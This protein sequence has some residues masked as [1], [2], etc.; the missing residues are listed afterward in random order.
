MFSRE[1]AKSGIFTHQTPWLSES[2]NGIPF[3]VTLILEGSVPLILKPVYPIPAP[4][5]EVV[6]TDGVDEIKK[7]KS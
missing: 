6:T 3:I 2:F 7:G 5:S 4:A 1:E